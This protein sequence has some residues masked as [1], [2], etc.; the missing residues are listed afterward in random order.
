MLSE[1]YF[2]KGEFLGQ[3]RRLTENR[4][5]TTVVEWDESDQ[6]LISEY[7]CE[8]KT[9]TCSPKVKDGKMPIM[10]KQR[11]IWP[12]NEPEGASVKNGGWD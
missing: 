10:L 2:A 3:R 7:T 11:G 12:G 6:H 8:Y 9:K 1:G 5:S 4:G